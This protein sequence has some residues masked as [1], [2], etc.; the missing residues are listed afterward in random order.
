MPASAPNRGDFAAAMQR[1][2]RGG[3][4]NT[5]TDVMMFERGL[6]YAW[7]TTAFAEICG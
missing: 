1:E 6:S 3:G 5:E 7:E 4:M 2:G